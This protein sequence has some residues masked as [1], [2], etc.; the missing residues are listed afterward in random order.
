MGL[1]HGIILGEGLICGCCLPLVSHRNKLV[2]LHAWC[3]KS[4]SSSGL[5]VRTHVL[6]SLTWDLSPTWPWALFK[7]IPGHFPVS[8]LCCSLDAVVVSS[9]VKGHNFFWANCEPKIVDD[10]IWV[11]WLF[12]PALGG[13]FWHRQGLWT[14]FS[15]CHPAF[16]DKWHF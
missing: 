3:L 16:N 4:S 2:W 7:L 13:S 8:E 12:I 6:S 9:S 15:D 11:R 5:F 10:E 14:H 1:Y